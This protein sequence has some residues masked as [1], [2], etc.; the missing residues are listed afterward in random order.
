MSAARQEAV[1]TASPIYPPFMSGPKNAGVESV[2]VPLVWNESVSHYSF[3]FD[4]ME[5]AIESSETKVGTFLLCNPH[6]PIGRVFTR[7]ELEA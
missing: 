5:R 2:A 3:D 4:A 1:M 6:N 7:G